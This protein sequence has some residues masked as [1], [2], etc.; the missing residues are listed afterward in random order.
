MRGARVVI[1]ARRGEAA[2]ERESDGDKWDAE[3]FWVGVWIGT[4]DDESRVNM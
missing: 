3:R 4:G 2:R 1:G